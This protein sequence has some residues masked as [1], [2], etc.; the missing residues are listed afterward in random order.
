[1]SPDTFSIHVGHVQNVNLEKRFS[2]FEDDFVE[3]GVVDGHYLYWLT[4]RN[5]EGNMVYRIIKYDITIPSQPRLLGDFQLP[6]KPY[7]WR[8]MT[9]RSGVVYLAS[10]GTREGSLWTIDSRDMATAAITQAAPLSGE[11]LQLAL[12]ENLLTLLGPGN[13]L[14]QYRISDLLQPAYVRRIDL[15]FA[16]DQGRTWQHGNVLYHSQ[17]GQLSIYTVA[18]DFTIK[19]PASLVFSTA[20]TGG[21]ADDR[22]AAILTESITSPWSNVAAGELH[23]IDVSSPLSPQIKSKLP[24]P[25]NG[26]AG[27]LISSYPFI[28]RVQYPMLEIYNMENLQR[29]LQVGYY[30]PVQAPMDRDRGYTAV[31]STGWWSC[32]ISRRTR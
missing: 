20:I 12:Q 28:Y 24:L 27:Q 13:C 30:Y 11:V 2:A 15:P 8:T 1:M 17:G 3:Q 31:I 23:I 10:G 19:G 16:I 29:P 26:F 6:V 9:V 4:G 32:A 22:V 25:T 21:C 18:S 7:W 14:N 5:G